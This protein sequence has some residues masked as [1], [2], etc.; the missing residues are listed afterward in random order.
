M[1]LYARVFLDILESLQ[2]FEDVLDELRVYPK[3]L[4]EA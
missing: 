3:D 2:D 1:F 4:N